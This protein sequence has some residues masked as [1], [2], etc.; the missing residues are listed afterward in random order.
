LTGFAPITRGRPEL[1]VMHKLECASGGC[2][3]IAGR[4]IYED[5]ESAVYRFW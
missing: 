5:E 3:E 2:G 1:I 4:M